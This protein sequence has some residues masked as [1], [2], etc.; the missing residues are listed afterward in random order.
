VK[1]VKESVDDSLRK[2]V[3]GGR[4]ESAL[5]GALRAEFRKRDRL[6]R[7]ACEEAVRAVMLARLN[8]NETF[9]MSEIISAIRMAGD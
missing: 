4:T 2:F 8:R 5:E 7:E 1:T 6:Q 9:D 3:E